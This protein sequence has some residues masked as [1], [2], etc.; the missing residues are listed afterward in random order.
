MVHPVGDEPAAYG[1]GIRRSIRLSYG[2]INW[3]EEAD[4]FALADTT[5]IF[6][7]WTTGSSFQQVVKAGLRDLLRALQAELPEAE[8][9]TTV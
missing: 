7:A 4:C 1:T 9:E 8:A 2:C 3:V 6:Q 5:L